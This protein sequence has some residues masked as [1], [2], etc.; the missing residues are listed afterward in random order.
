MSSVA[1]LKAYSLAN[2]RVQLL[3]GAA[4]INA[5]STLIVTDADT[6]AL[7]PDALAAHRNAKATNKLILLVKPEAAP[8][9]D[10][11]YDGRVRTFVASGKLLTTLPRKLG[12]EQLAYA[13]TTAA[14]ALPPRA[15]ALDIIHQHRTSL[16]SPEMNNRVETII[17]HRGDEQQ[18]VA[19]ALSMLNQ[20]CNNH[21]SLCLDQQHIPEQLAHWR[22]HPRI[23]CFQV[24]PPHAGPYII[25]QHFAMHTH[26]TFIAFQDSDDYSLPCRLS[27]QLTTAAATGADIVGSHELRVDDI[28][29]C[30]RAVRFP[31]DANHA[32]NNGG[33]YPALFP[34]TIIRSAAFKRVGGLSTCRR[35][36][37]DAQ[38][39]F[40]AGLQLRIRNCDE[41]L[42]IRRKRPNS[43][44]TA[45]DTGIYSPQRVALFQ[46]WRAA[47][48][49][50]RAGQ[51]ALAASALV[52][53]HSHQ[54]YSIKRLL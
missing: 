22:H 46:Q 45:V 1:K 37:S 53:E 5:D 2:G 33:N 16:P 31:L 3:Q 21:I 47:Y 23:K 6:H 8:N 9:Y 39:L 29:Q 28:N 4:A 18:L 34:S 12:I 19:S 51:Q 52:P 43:L 41:F 35:F 7:L 20:H 25:R 49:A 50:I 14:L 54:T 27:R 13:L 42:Y 26:A 48:N 40:N 30:L 17:P 10:A 24:Q 36:G 32:L 15:V 11:R 44:T 38:F